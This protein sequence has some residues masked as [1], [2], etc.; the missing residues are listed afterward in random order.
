MQSGK[1]QQITWP[2]VRIEEALK[3]SFTSTL[4]IGQDEAH[5]IYD[6]ADKAFRFVVALVHGD[7]VKA[8]VT[9]LGFLAR[10]VGFRISDGVLRKLNREL[11]IADAFIEEGDLYV[12]AKIAIRKRFSDNKFALILGA[13]RR[14]MSFVLAALDRDPS[15]PVR[16]HASALG[17]EAAAV[18]ARPAAFCSAYF[19][20]HEPK[21]ACAS[22][23]GRGRT[24]FTMRECGTCDGRGFVDPSL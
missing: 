7:G 6:V 16:D 13:W 22:C 24:T 10:F 11:H 12:L 1:K 9:E 14:D 8:G 4:V 18:E 2:R 20:R 19:W 5:T 23:S 21:V 3:S 17:F 15:D